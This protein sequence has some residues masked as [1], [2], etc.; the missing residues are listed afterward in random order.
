MRRLSDEKQFPE[1]HLLAGDFL[2]FRARDFDRARAQYEAGE[3]V[4][5]G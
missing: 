5:A 2:Y 1:G 3:G 4:S